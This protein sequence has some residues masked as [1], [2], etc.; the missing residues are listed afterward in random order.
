MK[1]LPDRP[2][3]EQVAQHARDLA[4][5]QL[6]AAN[7]VG[8]CEMQVSGV[9]GH[10]QCPN[11]GI[12]RVIESKIVT[13]W[14]EEDNV[15]FMCPRHFN[16]YLTENDVTASELFHGGWATRLDNGDWREFK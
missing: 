8:P 10:S 16:V 3:T 4:A 13:Y 14:D 2:T 6:A 12:I 11:P 1:N 15:T 9:P 5:S 7:R